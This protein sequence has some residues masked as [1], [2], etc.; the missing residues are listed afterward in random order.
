MALAGT[1]IKRYGITKG[2]IER[3]PFQSTQV[4]DLLA[5]FPNIFTYFSQN[6]IA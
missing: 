5:V 2:L 6:K 4:Y 1:P 3:Y